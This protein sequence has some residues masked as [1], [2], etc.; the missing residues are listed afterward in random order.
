M[1][2]SASVGQAV[3][4]RPQLSYVGDVADVI[5][6]GRVK[7]SPECQDSGEPLGVPPGLGNLGK[8]PDTDVP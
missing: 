2:S 7:V 3:W 5:L 6:V 8:C 1:V 4:E